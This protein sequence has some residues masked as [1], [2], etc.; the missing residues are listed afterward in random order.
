MLI[1]KKRNTRFAAFVIALSM[2]IAFIIPYAMDLPGIA[3]TKN[4]GANI[5]IDPSAELISLKGDDN[6]WFDT[7][8]TTIP[9]GAKDMSAN[10]TKASITTG[11]NTYT[12]ENGSALT[13]DVG[14][15]DPAMLNID[16]NYEFSKEELQD[17][18]TSH[19]VYYQIDA[20]VQLSNSYF[21][22]NMTVTDAAWS[23]TKVSG[24]YSISSDGLIVIHY[25]DDYIN[26][27]ANSNGLKGTIGFSGNVSRAED[28]D[29][30][31][32]IH[33]GSAEITLEFDD[34]KPS[35]SKDG[36]V[37]SDNGSIYIDW[38]ITINNPSGYVDMSTY[39]LTDTL[40]G[41]SIDWSSMSNLTFTPSGSVTQNADG[42]LSFTGTPETITI[43]YRQTG[44]A[45]G[46]TY[47]NKASITDGTTPISDEKEVEIEN[48]LNVSKSG[49]PDYEI[50]SGVN[51]EIFW[52]IDVSHK[53]GGSLKNV[54]IT[55]EDASFGSSV[56]VYDKA[57]GAVIDSSKY[58]VSG[59][60]ITFANDDSI[61]SA[62]TIQF[63]A[64]FSYTESGSTQYVTNHVKAQRTGD[65]PETPGQGIVNYSH[66]LSFKKELENLNQETGYVQWQFTLTANGENGDWNSK[67]NINGYKITDDAFA[68]LTDTDVA[69][70][71][72]NYYYHT[73]YSD[74]GLGSALGDNPYNLTLT[75][76]PNDATGKTIIITYDETAGTDIINK[77]KLYYDTTIEDSLSAAD[78]ASYNNGETVTV[79]NT[80]TATNDNGNMS[81]TDG[82]GRDIQQRIEADKTY[83]NANNNNNYSL[84]N[85][86]TDDRIL[87]WNVSITKD[88]GFTA[89][90]TYED[91][92]YTSDSTVGH[93]ITPA[94][95]TLISGSIK[96]AQSSTG[97]RTALTSDMY[98]I[99][100]YNAAGT[101]AADDENA[102][103]FKIEFTSA[104]SAS[105]Y[106]YIYFDY[107]STAM[108][109]DVQE[110]TSVKFSNGY[111][112]GGNHKTTDGMTYTR[113]DPSDVKTITLGV[114]KN[115]QDSKNAFG[116]RPDTIT[117]K[118][119]QAE[120]NADGTLPDT[121][122]WTEFGEYTLSA[123]SSN[124]SDYYTLDDEFPQ[125]KYENE[126]VT[127]YYYKIEEVTDAS[128][129]YTLTYTSD[130]V[131][132]TSNGSFTLT[133]KSDQTF[134]KVAVDSSGNRITQIDSA[135][136][137]IA[138]VDIDGT[139]TRCYMFRWNILMNKG[140]TTETYIDTLPANA[141]YIT[142]EDSSLSAYNPTIS[143]GSYTVDFYSSSWAGTA[144][145]DGTTLT[146]TMYDDPDTFTYYTAIP[147]SNLSQSLDEDGKLV[148]KVSK[149]GTEYSASVEI[150]GS[151]TEIE[152]DLITKEAYKG[153]VGGYLNYSIDINPNGK[154]LSNTGMIDITDAVSFDGGSKTLD[155]LD[156]TLYS[157]NVYPIVDG[158]VDESSPLSG[159]EYSYTVDYD[160][161]DTADCSV[162]HGTNSSGHENWVIEGWS[163][164]DEIAVTF[165]GIPNQ[166]CDWNIALVYYD[167]GGSRTTVKN[168]IILDS[169]GKY[170][171]NYT[172]PDA[173]QSL[174]VENY[175]GN[176]ITDV[177][178]TVTKTSPAVLNI[179]VPDQQA[180]RI[181]YTYAV[182]GWEVGDTLKFSNSASF[183]ADN[184][185]GETSTNSQDMNTTSSATSE[186]ERYPEIYK[187]DVSNYAMN[188]LSSAFKVAKYVEGTGWVYASNVETIETADST[189]RKF[190]FPASPYTNYVESDD[191]Y[192]AAAADLV[193]AATDD[194]STVNDKENVHTFDLS[195]HTLYKF[196][197]VTAPENYR[198]PNWSNGLS[199]NEEFI[200]YYD[201][202]E[203]SGTI[204]DDAN[205][206]VKTI[207]K[208]STI[209]ITN[210]QNIEL[211][212]EKSFS[213]STEN[214]P[215]ESQVVL[216]L[217]WSTSKKGT[218]LRLVSSDDLDVPASLQATQTITYKNDGSG[219]SASWSD[220]PSGKNGTPI[221]YFVREISYTDKD[222]VTYTYDEATGKYLNGTEEGPFKPVYT[223]NGTNTNGTVIEVN[224]SEGIMVR[225][226]WVD[227][228]GKEVTPPN[229]AGSTTEKMAVGFTVYGIKGT[230]RTKLVLPVTE[231]T[232]DDNYEYIL[233]D[234]V[235]DE[236][237]N[238][239]DLSY[240]DNF[241]VAENLTS[242][243][244]LALYGRYMS[245]TTRKISDGTGVLEIIN[246]SLS[247]STTNAIVQKVWSDNGEDHSNDSIT[248]ML[249]QSTL[250]NLTSTQLENIA[251]G[252]AIAG[253]YTGSSI[254]SSDDVKLIEKG[255]SRSF[256]YDGKT[257]DT[258]VADNGT[259]IVS[260]SHE[261]GTL[262]I[263]GVSS[264]SAEITITFTDST[265][266]EFIVSVIEYEITLGDQGDETVLWR[267]T[268]SDLPYSD[269]NDNN[270]YYYAVEKVVPEDYSVS[271][272]KTTTSAGQSTTITNSIPT[273]LIIKKNWADSDGNMI[274][275]DE[276]SQDYD[277]T[278]AAS[279]PD[280]ITVQVYQKLRTETVGG[281]SQTTEKPNNLKIVAL[282]DSITNGSFNGVAESDRYWAK[283]Q[284]MLRDNDFTNAAVSNY[285]ID[286]NEI[287]DMID[288]LD[289]ISFSGVT[290]LNLLAGTNDVLHGKSSGASD[291]FE[292]LVR[293]IFTKADA[294]GITDFELYVGT[295]P[296]ITILSW[297]Q[298]PNANPTQ[299]QANA[300]V[301]AYN[302]AITQVVNDLIDEG[303]NITL[304]DVN[305]AVDVI[306]S[307]GNALGE[308]ETMLADGCHPNAEGY[309]AI[310]AAFFN[311]I[312]AK[313]TS[314][315]E[316]ITNPTNIS[317]PG[318][319]ADISS[320]FSGTLYGTYTLSKSDGY[321]LALDELP[322]KNSLG[323][324]YV[325][326]IKEQGTHVLSGDGTY[327][328]L[329]GD[330]NK[331][332]EAVTYANNGQLAGESGT[333][334]ITNKIKTIGISVKKTWNDEED[335]SADEITVRLH[336]ETVA[337]SSNAQQNSLT[338]ALSEEAGSTISIPVSS[339][340]YTITSNKPVNASVDGTAINTPTTDSSKKTWT[341]TPAAGASVGDTA[342]ITFTDAD[343]QTITLTVQI[344]DDPQLTLTL[345]NTTV[346]AGEAT[347]SISTIMFTPPGGTETSLSASDANVSFT[348]SNPNVITIDENGVMTVVNGGTADITAHYLYNGETL[349]SNAVSVTVDLPDFTADN[350]EVAEGESAQISIT[351]SYGTFTYQSNDTSVATVDSDGNVTGEAAGSATITITRTEDN[352]SHDITVTVESASTV[353]S[354]HITSATDVQLDE[355]KYVQTVTIVIDSTSWSQLQI[356]VYNNNTIIASDYNIYWWDTT[357]SLYAGGQ[358][359]GGDTFVM[360]INAYADK[361]SFDPCSGS[362][363]YSIEYLDSA[364][365]SISP[366]PRK[367][368]QQSPSL[369]Q[370]SAA[371]TP[372]SRFSSTL[373]TRSAA[374]AYTSQQLTLPSVTT[375]LSEENADFGSNDYVD[376]T[377]K[378]TDDW[379]K[380]VSGL[381]VYTFDEGVL[382]SYYYWAEE[383]AINGTAVSGYNVS[384]AF[385]DGDSATDYS[386]NASAPGETPTIA[387]VNTP[388]ETTEVELPDTG[389][390]GTKPYTAAGLAIMSLT[391]TIYFFKRRG[392][393]ERKSA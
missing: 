109:S 43:T 255:A 64:G 176:F 392:R 264:G 240:F 167:Q 203:Y 192:P 53:S 361:V 335:H 241:E 197:E 223:K 211:S 68:D 130:P 52:S 45:L 327:Y 17:I 42:T 24:Y 262:T 289:Q 226:L 337:D 177:T 4:A 283:L 341:I 206:K 51:D 93:F 178:A 166:N 365:Q 314:G 387:I 70:I 331:Y 234:T 116:G 239:Y 375:L 20:D 225:K 243:Q 90:D 144:S 218:N 383:I 3:L 343:D 30:D 215:D 277:E 290:K 334:T 370:S 338:L 193:F 351:P 23:T 342:T 57:T 32:T 69:N 182:T 369:T 198:Q 235:E 263:A 162:N 292:T 60:T 386:I 269:E 5:S 216:G 136:V 128:S 44:V 81:G 201:Y 113:D 376:I 249:V 132:A 205:G 174:S 282:G 50:D 379:E 251:K 212:A 380:L 172:I 258:V 149:D 22:E 154:K 252:A 133:N 135:S 41:D 58:T 295:I 194:T 173:A 49:K 34:S 1:N 21:G 127:K 293:A 389:G 230:T 329:S 323:V 129:G 11:G 126:T 79:S 287:Q 145:A 317:M 71:G 102:V 319:D 350:I 318:E 117:V 14:A 101:V 321:K 63:M 305:S 322:E 165:T 2:V 155:D 110:G 153:A 39:T 138:T 214:L 199:G 227:L 105:N 285:G 104:V 210:N 196:V 139:P 122:V 152:G 309:A 134:G 28:A 96:G 355:S 362:L 246:T 222:G 8:V 111:D 143:W 356:K 54:V 29:G 311:A 330:S 286:G 56:T 219:T 95:R 266:E 170:T 87:Y 91:T 377:I 141:V 27:L 237:G 202:D 302:T 66:E 100:F 265:T 257:I 190:T 157:I 275:T 189:Y 209:N 151:S 112:F 339:A 254:K 273:Q 281:S 372:L 360:E 38:Q 250:S 159:G 89:G 188:Y 345:N 55:D 18:L 77:I 391:G 48:G 306:D 353:L 384:Y 107:A 300:L 207:L 333:V 313:Y 256:T 270:Y 260:L 195:E 26:Y 108:T 200:F 284:Q 98:T 13:I 120:A 374:Q 84:G 245:E 180:Y 171:F 61:P 161:T 147:V 382:V 390:G 304:V 244:Q 97:E 19:Y 92:L 160:V 12:S 191:M 229:E 83:G 349:D 340:G 78:W 204:P 67:E 99:T 119:Y 137:P 118:I 47:N 354:E 72:F 271:Y 324:E 131:A 373:L 150:T 36:I 367:L 381:P 164:G 326:Y 352:T 168:G 359:I 62:V 268:W 16:L 103:G 307:S 85:E 368:S 10:I 366:A 238:T 121:P 272:R 114:T 73:G 88:A 123:S 156:L 357:N 310:A 393:R 242:D 303:Y 316:T 221:Y 276:T 294:A 184:G 179:S 278:M 236:S 186:A 94:Q 175:Y 37:G 15:A 148:N 59:N 298:Y 261:N 213:G 325:Y 140:K 247:S 6:P 347:P 208:N 86:D 297:F 7:P 296:Y 183:E 74:T 65:I 40:G 280:E 46:E 181:V 358:T 146:V 315:S 125:W 336:R 228:N 267:Y 124:S 344:V 388:S 142:G 80:A 363:T 385:T 35:I 364:P 274:V 158:V 217:Y 231:L 9:S 169:E 332:I 233:P 31:K 312:N 291:R 301:D 82:D 378:A 232:Y 348:S 163:P 115:W 371:Q 33:I 328:T 187:T 248:V 259:G 320:Q 288:R 106:H 25:T 76:D 185:S 308:T 279:L 346:T 220:L 224:N 75:K 299:A 253:V